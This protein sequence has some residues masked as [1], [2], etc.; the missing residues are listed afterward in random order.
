MPPKFIQPF[1]WSNDFKK[2]DL[3][4]DK[5]RIILNLLNFGTKRATDW[6]FSY[7][8]KSE[9]KKTVINHGAKGE[10][11]PKSLNYWQLILNID[12]KKLIRSR[13]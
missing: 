5:N 7:Y 4:R 9:I 13:L 1:F 8:P 6:L 3:K 11:S 10:L 2:I 12:S